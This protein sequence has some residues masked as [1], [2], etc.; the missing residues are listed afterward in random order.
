MTR[1]LGF[2]ALLLLLGCT[3]H[4]AERVERAF[5][6]WK[7]DSQISRA[8]DSLIQAAHVGKLYVKFFEV[9]PDSIL[10]NRPTAKLQLYYHNDSLKIVPTVFIRN[11]VF[12]N[13]T[14]KS[15]DA[16]AGNV[17]FLLHKYARQGRFS[18]DSITEYQMDC[19]WTKSTKDN[20]FYF[21]EALKKVS[22]KQISCTLRLYPYKYQKEMG[23]PPVDRVMLMCY[24]LNNPLDDKS[25]NSILDM[26]ELD[27]YLG[28]EY[29]LPLD[30]ALPTYSWMLVYQ[31]DRFA[32]LLR[33]EPSDFNQTLKPLR[34]MWFEAT[35][36]IVVD[37]F[38]VRR[39]DRIKY[40]MVSGKQLADAVARIKKRVRLDDQ[41]TVAFFHL[42]QTQLKLYKSEEINHLY[43]LFTD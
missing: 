19:D 38:Y 33:A 17:N 40:E 9:E 2:V 11:E 25:T 20:Y 4:R 6:F 14:K 27:S 29:P 36:D 37:G 23:V 15:L 1:F 30:I 26:R 7:S 32:K 34:P 12:R 10:G 28:S 8:E 41:I 18:G 21:L 5:Y 22:G 35:Q 43:T 31:N 42:D 39:G 13:A 16:L 24:S 3:S